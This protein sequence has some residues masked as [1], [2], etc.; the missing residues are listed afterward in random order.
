MIAQPPTARHPLPWASAWGVVLGLLLLRIAYVLWLMPY[1]LGNDEAQYWTWTRHLDWSYLSKPPLTTWVMF[2]TTSVLGDTLLGVKLAALVGQGVVSLLAFGLAGARSG[3]LAAWLALALTATVP[4]V[5]AGG[6]LMSPD[7]LLLP[8]WMGAL[9][10]LVKE[11]G[12]PQW[13]HWV[14]I[15]VL[16]GLAGLAKYTAVV[17]Y[18]LLG[19]WMLLER[20]DLWA[21]PHPYVAGMMS[22]AFQAP[23]LYWNMT[24]GWAGL[25]HVLWQAD[26]GGDT[27]HGGVKTLVD[28]LLNQA[29][30]LGPTTFICLLAAWMGGL[31]SYRRGAPAMRMVWL[32]TLPIFLVFAGQALMAKVQPNWPL[33]GTVPAL[34]LLAAW[35]AH[36]GRIMQYVVVGGVML[37]AF[38]SLI[39][40]DTFILRAA[41]FDFPH[42]ADPTKDMQGWPA[43]GQ[44]LGTVMR[45]LDKDTVVLTS[46]YQTAAEL[47]FH[48][49]HQPVVAYINAE[50][51]RATEYDLWTWP[52]LDTAPLI[53]YVNEQPYLPDVIKTRF[54][55]CTR[56]HT[57]QA[58]RQGVI[59]R[60]M[61]LWLCWGSP[62]PKA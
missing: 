53:V 19:V 15:G 47:Q 11:D 9:W 23:V 46:R 17:F 4:L 59:Q 56:W 60:Q 37:N 49:P 28:F 2:L 57:L 62:I 30:V 22:L 1:G 16:I 45:G 24:H 44:T 40:H 35:V 25:E 52:E 6:L 29:L 32:M 7:A 5:A 61:H 50:N 39:L 38:I 42:K 33:L 10:L 34:T 8:L 31:A 41:G 14:G 51:R 13:R 58:E 54:A 36:Q 20:R 21:R 43:I 26:G 12:P 18:P 48:I 55:D 27:R 3:A